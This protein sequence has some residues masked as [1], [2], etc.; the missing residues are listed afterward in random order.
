MTTSPEMIT[1]RTPVNSANKTMGFL[2]RNIRTK[3][4]GIRG[5]AYKTLVRPILEYSSPVWNPYT[6]SNIH[7][8]EMARRTAARWTLGR[9]FSYDSVSGMLG[10]LGWKSPEN[11]RTDA[12]LCLFYNIVLCLVAVSLTPYVVHSQVPRRHSKSYSLAFRQIHTIADY[13]SS[14][15]HLSSSDV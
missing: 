5:V 15:L 7:R 4:P 1:S 3:D 2:R 13:Y 10:E 8:I 14:F 9:F 6:R 12:R 11:R